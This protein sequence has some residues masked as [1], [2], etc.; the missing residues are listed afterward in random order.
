M[1]IITRANKPLHRTAIPLRSIDAGEL[2]RCQRE[3]MTEPT[4]VRSRE[5]IGDVV[6]LAREIWTDHYVPIIGREQ[7]DYMLEKFQ[8]EKAI[9]TQ[10]ADGED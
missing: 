4:R 10:L 3:S 5:Q 8:S 1:S 9:A 2:G 7:V 6:N